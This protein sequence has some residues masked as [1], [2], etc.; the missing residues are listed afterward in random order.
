M[1]CIRCLFDLQNIFTN[2]SRYIDAIHKITKSQITKSQ[3]VFA[4]IIKKLI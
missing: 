2:F 4:I 3:K 1:E